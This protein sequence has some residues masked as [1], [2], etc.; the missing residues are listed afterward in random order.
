MVTIKHPKKLGIESSIV[1]VGF[2]AISWTL[3]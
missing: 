2:S 3:P 1:V